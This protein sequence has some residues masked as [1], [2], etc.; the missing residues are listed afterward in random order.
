MSHQRSPAPHSNESGGTQRWRRVVSAMP[1]GAT[2][3]S[4]AMSPGATGSSRA[5]SPVHAAL[6]T[7]VE[8]QRTVS[9]GQAEQTLSEIEAQVHSFVARTAQVDAAARELIE[10]RRRPHVDQRRVDAVQAMLRDAIATMHLPSTVPPAPA[11]AAAS[12]A[13]A[14]GP[15]PPLSYCSGGDA[16]GHGELVAA[17]PERQRKHYRRHNLRADQVRSAAAPRALSDRWPW[18][19]ALPHRFATRLTFPR[20]VHRRGYSQ[21]GSTRITR[22]RTRRSRRR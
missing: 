6:P 20:R 21:N 16:V 19:R 8:L 7:A 2:G 1:L 15:F 5:M 14:Q 4:R 11:P 18:A 13:S 17:P 10:L 12:A 3:S 9:Q 22:T